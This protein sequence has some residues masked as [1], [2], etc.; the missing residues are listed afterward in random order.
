M[1]VLNNVLDN[2][3]LESGH[4]V[5]ASEPFDLREVTTTSAEIFRALANEKRLSLSIEIDSSVQAWYLGDAGRIRQIIQN[6]V[7]NAVKF[8]D[9]GEISV[10]IKTEPE[11][12][13]VVR[14]PG[15]GMSADE[16]S[17]IFERYNQAGSVRSQSGGTG[18]GLAI[19]R[20]IA[21]A[22]GGDLTVRS[23]PGLG[24]DFVLLLRLPVASDPKFQLPSI[25]V[26]P[27]LQVLVVEDEPVN[28]VVS[29]ALL[30]SMGHRVTVVA[31]GQGALD[32]VTTRPY[33]IV[34]MDS[35]LPDFSGLEATRR[36]RKSDRGERTPILG[37]TANAYS[38][39]LQECLAA[40]MNAVITKPVT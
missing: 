36:I 25:E 30:E 6:L 22:M 1:S 40:G 38:D 20:D 4:L 37:L 3:K 26:I 18:L 8:T 13:V 27:S 24:S 32:A 21:R 29:R 35:Q 14:D 16:T 10:L 23:V 15:R 11:L 19:S 12:I 31:S 2:A 5:V 33:D 17:R 39:H 28:Q 7:H 9:R 34:L